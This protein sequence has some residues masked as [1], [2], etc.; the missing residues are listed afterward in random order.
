MSQETTMEKIPERNSSSSVNRANTFVSSL[1]TL[2]ANNGSNFHDI[3][4]IARDLLSSSL[5]PSLIPTLLHE[6]KLYLKNNL[7][8]ASDHVVGGASN[9]HFIGNVISIIER[10]FGECSEGDRNYLSEGSVEVMLLHVVR[11][12][13]HMGSSGLAFKLRIRFCSMVCKVMERKDDLFFL[14]EIKFR[15]KLVEHVTDWLMCSSIQTVDIDKHVLRE[16]DQ[17]AVIAVGVLLKG[18]PLHPDEGDGGDVPEAKSQLFLKYFTLF[19]K[20]LGECSDKLAESELLD[21]SASEDTVTLRRLI[22]VAM[23]NLLSANIESGLVHAMSLAYHD[24]VQT[25]SAFLEVLTKIVQQGSDGFQT[26][27]DSVSTERFERLVELVTMMGDNGELPIANALANVVHT[28]YMDE[29]ARVFVTLFD[30]KHLLYQLLWNMFTKEVEEA[31]SV[32]TLFRGNSLASKIMTFCFKV[33]GASYLHNLVEPL[34]AWSLTQDIVNL[35]FEVDQKR[36]PPGYDI[37]QCRANLQRLTE[38]FFTRIMTSTDKFPPQLKSVCHCLYQVVSQRFHESGTGAV[39]SAIFLRFLNPAIATPYEYG[40]SDRRL[41]PNL[42]RAFKFM[43]KIMQNIANHVVFTKEEHMKHFNEFVSARFDVCQQFFMQISTPECASVESSGQSTSFMND[44]NV[45]ALHRLLWNDQEKIG[46]YLAKSR[47]GWW[48]A[49][50][51]GRRPFDKMVTLLAYIGPPEYTRP[52]LETRMTGQNILPCKFEELMTKR[53]AADSEEYK[54]VKGLNIFYQFGRSKM[55][56]PVFYYVARRYVLHNIREDILMFYILQALKPYSARKF[57]IIIDLTHVGAKNRFRGQYLPKWL[58]LYPQQIYKNLDTVYVYNPNTWVRDY[59]SYNEGSF[60][61]VEGHRS[62]HFIED[63]LELK[64]F[65]ELDHQKVPSATRGL[66]E[67]VTVYHNA[68]RLGQIHNKVHV[69]VGSKAVQLTMVDKTKLLGYDVVLNDIYYA[70]EIEAI[71]FTEATNTFSLKV[72]T[73]NNAVMSFT[74]PDA[75]KIVEG[76]RYIRNRWEISQPQQM[77]SHHKIEAKDVPGTLLNMA[78]LNLGCS[79]PLV[80]SS[81]YN[82]LCVLTTAF[83]LQLEGRLCESDG[84][85]IPTNNAL[86]IISISNTLARNENHLTLEFLEECITGFRYSND[87]L[88]NLCLEYME[89]WLFNLPSFASSDG[90]KRNKVKSVVEKLIDLTITEKDFYLSVQTKIWGNFGQMTSLVDLVLECF[91]ETS[92]QGGL[93]SVKAEVMADT[94]VALAAHNMKLV[95]SKIIK[96][97]CRLV[98]KTSLRPTPTLEKHKHWEEIAILA[99]YLLMLSFNNN[100]DVAAHL[101]YLFHL[102]SLLVSTGPLTLRASIHG[103]VV[104][105]IHSLLTCKQI[106]FK[107]ETQQI[108]RL[109]LTEFCL[110]KFYTLFGIPQVKSAADAAFKSEAI[111]LGHHPSV[112]HQH[113]SAVSSCHDNDDVINLGY[114]DTV[115][116]AMLEVMEACMKDIRGSDWLNEWLDLSHKFAFQYNPSL[117][118]R[119][120]VVLGCI[121]KHGSLRHVKQILGIM[122]RSLEPQ[123]DPVLLEASVL[124]L[125]RMQL[126]INAKPEFHVNFFW[127]GIAMMQLNEKNLYAAGILLVEQNLHNLDE[128]DAFVQQPSI[129][130]MNCKVDRHPL[131][132]TV[133]VC[134]KSD[135]HFAFVTYLLKGFRHNDSTV[136]SRVVRI[137]DFSLELISRHRGCNKYDVNLDSLPYIAAL[138]PVCADARRYCVPRRKPDSSNISASSSKPI[139]DQTTVDESANISDENPPT[140]D[141]TLQEPPSTPT[142]PTTTDKPRKHAIKVKKSTETA[143]DSDSSSSSASHVTSSS[144]TSSMRSSRRKHST[145]VASNVLLDDEMLGQKHQALLLTILATQVCH[146]PNKSDVQII[147]EYLAEASSVFP[148][149]FPIV[150]SLLDQK[151]NSVLNYCEDP[152]VLSHVQVIVRNA[153]LCV[154]DNIIR[155]ISFIQDIGFGGLCKFVGPFAKVPSLEHSSIIVKLIDSLI[156]TYLMDVPDLTPVQSRLSISSALSAAS[157]DAVHESEDSDVTNGNGQNFDLDSRQPPSGHG[158]FRNRGPKLTIKVPNN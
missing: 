87:K 158:N 123:P 86:F 115:V 139:V 151:I 52:V 112:R 45:S 64:K 130:L 83:N 9:D 94:S 137:L 143:R 128:L 113:D 102:V 62:I 1:L 99:R 19:M 150:H 27:G 136:V 54:L 51:V 53:K 71:H 55:G 70:H 122:E 138:L 134:F 74:H 104:N 57:D 157:L 147:Y 80:R 85:C 38:R 146:T 23:S 84:L 105:I 20:L 98:D 68:W 129:I 61:Q 50:A 24:E 15:N 135:F 8:D 43:C 79:K 127:L 155:N 116:D 124:C 73:N 13:R 14:F 26:L 111:V 2:V 33:Y 126:I 42:A 31:D 109:S 36:I 34:V 118:P 110:P 120:L 65:I 29:L 144:M 10:V 37:L 93:G 46:R 90:I 12:V 95:S 49:K 141:P 101:P 60:N 75:A 63:L 153:L 78:L 114:L 17:C 92:S 106:E 88:K 148:A 117:Q 119:A 107:E 44:T 47:W 32:Q 142:N 11:Y 125:T 72:S 25:R 81:A 30:A 18:L 140:R 103:L 89:P 154:D 40:L 7:F 35:H 48:N 41:P 91:I 5:H 145:D 3:S 28:S 100:L 132:T 152:V 58:V 108:L 6:I 69:K 59:V 16:L 22:I 39:A 67:D 56:Y 133:N 77:V 156:T 4:E 121:A 149:V 21:E 66:G 97:L 96:R 76:I 82:L 131:D